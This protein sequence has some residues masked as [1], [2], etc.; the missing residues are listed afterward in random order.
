MSKKVSLV[1]FSLKIDG[2]N[3]K[4]RIDKKRFKKVENHSMLARMIPTTASH[5]P[6]F[7]K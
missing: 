2:Q 4:H 5:L 6:P 3:S 1:K 7:V